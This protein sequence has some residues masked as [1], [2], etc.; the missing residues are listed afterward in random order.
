LYI[1]KFI[2]NWILPPGIIILS[3]FLLSV[4][5]YRKNSRPAKALGLIALAFYLLSTPY[6]SHMLIGN[7][8]SQYHPPAKPVGDVV[9]VLGGGATFDTPNL[10]GEGHLSGSAANR[11]LTGILLERKLN[12]PIIIAGGQVYSDSGNEAQITRRLWQGLGATKIFIEDKSL[13][14]RQNAENVKKI[15]ESNGFK[16]PILVTSAFHMKRSVFY[17]E[18]SGVSVVPYPADYKVNVVNEV[19]VHNFIP[20][21]GSFDNSSVALKEYLGL[22][23]AVWLD[24]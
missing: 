20:S 17:F 10:D 8:E 16:N 7:L 24:Y 9:I 19:S 13:N 1:I 11:A 18:K 3:L 2:Y 14:T 23:G 22:A 15:L 4:C 21:A 5:L 12:V 6:F